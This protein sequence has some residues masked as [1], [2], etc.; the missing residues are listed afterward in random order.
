LF[1]D[2]DPQGTQ[3]TIKIFD[4]FEQ[5]NNFQNEEATTTM[6]NRMEQIFNRICFEHVEGIFELPLEIIEKIIEKQESLQTYHVRK[7]LFEYADYISSGLNP[8]YEKDFQ[9]P[10]K[11]WKHLNF[12]WLL[13]DDFYSNVI[14]RIFC[15]SQQEF[16]EE[17]LKSLSNSNTAIILLMDYIHYMKFSLQECKLLIEVVPLDSISRLVASDIKEKRIPKY[18]KEVESYFLEL[19]CYEFVESRKCKIVTGSDDMKVKLFDLENMN[20]CIQQFNGH[21]YDVTCVIVL[22]DGRL[23]TASDDKTIK[24]WN[25]K[26]G[27]SDHT[28]NGHTDWFHCLIEFDQNRIISC[29]DDKTIKIWNVNKLQCEKTL[30]GHT[31]SVNCIAKLDQNRIISGGYD[32]KLKIWNMNTFQCEYTIQSNHTKSIWC[33]LVLNCNQIV[34]GSY[35]KTIQIYDLKTKQCIS[36]LNGHS[37]CVNCIIKWNENYILSSSNDCT[38]KLWNLSTK[39]CEKTLQNNTDV[40]CIVKLD[41][42]YILSGDW[43]GFVKKWNIETGKCENKWEV[44]DK[45]IR[46]LALK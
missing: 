5:E 22:H 27:N 38:I 6:I 7:F 35:D 2:N 13:Q 33:I 21:T 14:E 19:F 25:T 42:N 39:Q 29:D 37:H 9:I 8:F 12:Y 20:N 41:S 1:S 28:F 32:K 15:Y 36:T 46:S 43:N 30:L 10:I 16:I 18:D 31:S 34:T 26:T 4:F 24:I 45:W 11:F 17:I 3:S 44:H 23:A 40:H